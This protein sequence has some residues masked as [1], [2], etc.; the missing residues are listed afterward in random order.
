MVNAH[1][2]GRQVDVRDANHVVLVHLDQRTRHRVVES[3]KWTLCN[4]G[5]VG[6][7][8]VHSKLANRWL[9]VANR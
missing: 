4:A 6:L 8:D 7:V 3:Q 9:H 2:L 5:K 1:V